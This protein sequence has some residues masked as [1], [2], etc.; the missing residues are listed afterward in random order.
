MPTINDDI[1]WLEEIQ[2]RLIAI[3]KRI[4]GMVPVTPERYDNTQTAH[5]FSA[6]AISGCEQTVRYLRKAI[7]EAIGGE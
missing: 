4:G 2:P 1:A 6:Q 3:N 7:Q 5:V